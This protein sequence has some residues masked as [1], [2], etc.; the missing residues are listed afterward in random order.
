LRCLFDKPL[1]DEFGKKG[2]RGQPRELAQV[3]ENETFQ[4]IA[5][6]KMQERGLTID[7]QRGGSER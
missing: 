6:D 3:T 4:D 5:R 2:G 7:E 1:W